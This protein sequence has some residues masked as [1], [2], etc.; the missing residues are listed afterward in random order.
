VR[1]SRRGELDLDC[2]VVEESSGSFPIDL[3]AF[4]ASNPTE[5]DRVAGVFD[6][7]AGLQDAE[8]DLVIVSAARPQRS[9]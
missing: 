7:E 2:I 6:F 3:V 4:L 9:R 8:G 1:P 5:A